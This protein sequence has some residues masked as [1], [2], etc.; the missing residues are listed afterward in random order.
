MKKRNSK[1]GLT[2]VEVVV[3][4]A[5][6][7]IMSLAGFSVV[8]FTISASSKNHLLHFFMTET[9]NYI[10][11]Y[12]SGSDNYADAMHLLTG[13]NYVYGTDSTIYYSSDLQITDEQNAKY[14]VD[15]DFDTS[16]MH[17]SCYNS[18]SSLIYEAEVWY[19]K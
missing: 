13:N 4:M 7:V 19:A 17:I 9:Q 8:N 3:A 6:V 12:V 16:N 14:H 1:K 5:L 18:Q 11:A 15:I 2:L 10:S